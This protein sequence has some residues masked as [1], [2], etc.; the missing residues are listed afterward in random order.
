M[1]KCT[2]CGKLNNAFKGDPLYLEDDK[3][4]CFGCAEPIRDELN[5]MYDA[6]TKEELDSLANSIMEKSKL[7]FD[8]EV[9]NYISLYVKKRYNN[10]ELPENKEESEVREQVSDDESGMFSNIGSKIKA[11]ATFVTC[12]GIVGSIIIGMVIIGNDE[13]LALLGI[14][15]MA[16]GS[17][18]AW[19]S[20]FVLYGFGQLVENSDKL[21]K[22]YFSLSNNTTLE[23]PL[24]DKLNTLDEWRR[25]GL[26]TEEEYNKKMENL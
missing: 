16:V 9:T 22:I 14:I 26:I 6:K 21:V 15:I 7:I 23:K 5:R 24:N 20:S 10:I 1:E 17:L 18:L 11:L 3:I 13:D 8:E 25:Q 4:L 2:C 12:V 19:I